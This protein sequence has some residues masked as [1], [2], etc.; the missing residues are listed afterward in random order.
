M[1]GGTLFIFFICLYWILKKLQSKH[2][3]VATFPTFF[4]STLYFVKGAQSLRRNE[5]CA[6]I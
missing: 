3:L 2:G 4:Y 6:Q 5:I 1:S